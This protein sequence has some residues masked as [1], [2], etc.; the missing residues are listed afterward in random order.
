MV[1]RKIIDEFFASKKFAVV[2]VSRNEKKFGNA[3]FKELK[4]KGYDVFPVNS[5]SEFINGEKCYNNLESL[6]EKVDGVVVVVPPQEAEKVVRE[7]EAANIKRV[8]L[9]Q[10]SQS[11]EVINFC[12][13]KGINVVYG[14]C[15]LMFAEPVKS[16]HK[17]HRGFKKIFGRL[18]K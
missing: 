7:A 13:E 4:A 6:P 11:D 9:Q 15:I 1:Q 16:F 12:V 10:G 8:W 5:K 14:E 3:V 17:I 2:G 18:P